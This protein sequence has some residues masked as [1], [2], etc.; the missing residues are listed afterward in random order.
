VSNVHYSLGHLSGTPDREITHLVAPLWSTMGC[1]VITSPEETP[2]PLGQPFPE[3]SQHKSSRR[4]H[5]LEINLR[6]T[7]SFSMNS[8][9]MDIVSW[10]L[11]KVPL[12][13]VIPLRTF[14]GETPINLV[15]YEVPVTEGERY[16]KRH[17]I[18]KLNHIFKVEVRAL[19]LPPPSLLQ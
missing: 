2:P 15:A 16:P 18:D 8:Y 9:N 14:T 4:Q 17:P 7:Y 6:D 19:R 1:V 12:L 10:N 5:E 13:Q 3:T 11:I